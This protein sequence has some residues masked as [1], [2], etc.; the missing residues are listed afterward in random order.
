[1]KK[2]NSR[3]TTLYTATDWIRKVGLSNDG[4]LLLQDDESL[5][6]VSLEGKIE[7]TYKKKIISFYPINGGILLQFL[8]NEFC[9]TKGNNFSIPSEFIIS[10]HSYNNDLIVVGYKNVYVCSIKKN[11]GNQSDVFC[12]NQN[13]EE[14]EKTLSSCLQKN[15]DNFF[16]LSSY[17]NVYQYNLNSHQLVFFMKLFQ[18]KIESIATKELFLVCFIPYLKLKE[19]KVKPQNKLENERS[20]GLVIVNQAGNQIEEDITKSNS[21]LG[22]KQID[23]SES[24]SLEEL[25]KTQGDFRLNTLVISRNTIFNIEN[26]IRILSINS[27][28]ENVTSLCQYR[29]YILIGTLEGKVYA[30][31]LSSLKL[32]LLLNQRRNISEMIVFP[33]D[34]LVINSIFSVFSVNLNELLTE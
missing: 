8:Q 18:E 29:K 2:T 10:I 3:I 28:I 32:Q 1:M 24:N 12:L 4:K 11:K 34:I 23:S 19:K 21:N 33:N 25:T 31:D 15:S 6:T 7:E 9:D 20:K 5:H 17:Y 26:G 22:G 27:E 14:K 30:F 13:F 16:V